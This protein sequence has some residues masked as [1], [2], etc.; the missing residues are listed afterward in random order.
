MPLIGFSASIVPYIMAIIFTM[1]FFNG[2]NQ[3]VSDKAIFT[4]TTTALHVVSFNNEQGVTSETFHQITKT[5]TD[6]FDTLFKNSFKNRRKC[7]IKR[8]YNSAHTYNSITTEALSRRGPPAY[9]S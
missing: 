4:G 2:N 9:I 7:K 3:G 6:V 8:Y 5:S 1:L